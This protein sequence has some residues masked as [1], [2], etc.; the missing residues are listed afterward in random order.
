MILDEIGRGTSTF[1]GLSIA[2]ATLEHLHNQNHCRTLFA[3]HYHELTV[4]ENQLSSISNRTVKIKEYE[5]E[6]VF[7]HKIVEGFSNHSF[8]IKVADLAGIPVA[9]TERAT[10]ILKRLE[11]KSGLKSTQE[12]ILQNSI[13]KEKENNQIICKESETYDFIQAL[14]IDNVTPKEALHLLYKIQKDLKS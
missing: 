14:E 4:L 6:L 1:D 2:W 8:G 9:V 3:T 12:K 5:G 7:L 10:E 11:N 13:K